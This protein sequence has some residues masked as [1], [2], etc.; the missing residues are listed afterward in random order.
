MLD[1]V[2]WHIYIQLVALGSLVV[3]CLPLDL[4][5]TG[6]NP[7][8]D[9]GFLRARKIRSTTSFDVEAKP[10]VPCRETL[11]HVEEPYEYERYTPKGKNHCNFLAKFISLR[12]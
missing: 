2:H 6:S 7:A 5:F 3:A 9:D 8:V 10:S 1:N 11:R 4:R 12:Y